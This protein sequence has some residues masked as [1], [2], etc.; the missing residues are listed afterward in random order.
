MLFGTLTGLKGVMPESRNI[1]AFL[2]VVEHRI[3]A[4]LAWDEQAS[5]SERPALAAAA[6]HLCMAP[7]AKRAR[8]RLTYYFGLALDAD[9]DLLADIA[10]AGEFI[11]AASLLHDDVIDNGRLRRGKPTVNV[12]W[13]SL[14]A[15]L[16]GDLLLAEAVKG[17]HRCPRD[18]AQESL[19]VVADM[20]RSTML[21]A[22]IRGSVNVP[23]KQWRYIA[24]GKTAS[25]FKWCGRSAAHLAEDA[26]ALERFGLFGERFGTAFQMADDLL[27]IVGLDSGKTPFADIRNCNP[28]Y[29]LI[30]AQ[31]KSTEFRERLRMAWAKET[32]SE[33]E[34]QSLGAE[35]V[36]LGAASETEDRIEEEIRLALEALGKYS[37]RPG[38]REI[39]QWAAMTWRQFSRSEA[40]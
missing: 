13:D 8:P 11:H 10:V 21:E 38:C 22:H 40:V 20:T 9:V 27:D 24:L 19:E 3:D 32:L 12:I 33:E 35:V 29:P 16:A 6:R 30:I 36:A 28:S 23:V 25:M 15:V 4:A 39:A 26:E 14:T 18:I 37:K 17:L 7:G 1:G 5:W 34:V 2:E 31:E